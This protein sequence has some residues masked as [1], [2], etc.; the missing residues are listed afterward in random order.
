MA[1]VFHSMCYASTLQKITWL[2]FHGGQCGLYIK[3]RPH[4]PHSPHHLHSIYNL[5]NLNNLNGNDNDNGNGNDK[6][7]SLDRSGH[8][9]VD[10]EY[11]VDSSNNGYSGSSIR[12]PFHDLIGQIAMFRPTFLSSVPA[13]WTEVY[14][15]YTMEKTSL[16][17]VYMGR[18]RGGDRRVDTNNNTNTD[19]DITT[20]YHTACLVLNHKY[21]NIFGDRLVHVSTGSAHTPTHILDFMRDVI[22]VGPDGNM[23]CL[24]FEGYGCMECGTIAHNNTFVGGVDWKIIPVDGYTDRPDRPGV[25]VGELIVKT[26]RMHAEYYNNPTMSRER[27]SHDGYFKTGDVV[28][29]SCMCRNKKLGLGGNSNSDVNSSGHNSIESNSTASAANSNTNPSNTSTSSSN[30]PTTPTKTSFE[31]CTCDRRYMKVKV[32]GRSIAMLKLADGEMYNPEHIEGLLIECTHILQIY[33]HVEIDWLA[34]V[35]IIVT[36]PELLGLG[37]DVAE[38]L[39]REEISQLSSGLLTKHIPAC[40]VLT[41]TPFDVESG[42]LTISMKTCRPK[43]YS[44]YRTALQDAYQSIEAKIMGA[45]MELILAPLFGNDTNSTSTDNTDNTDST[46]ATHT[47]TPTTAPT[48]TAMSIGA[49]G[50]TNIWSYGLNS[51]VALNMASNINTIY[52]IPSKLCVE[53]IY[54]SQTVSDIQESISSY[55][56]CN[57]TGVGSGTDRG[58]GEYRDDVDLSIGSTGLSSGSG[59]NGAMGVLTEKWK[60]LVL[61]DMQWRPNIGAGAGAGLGVSPRPSISIGG[62]VGVTPLESK[63]LEINPVAGLGSG[64]GTD[65]CTDTATGSATGSG[66]NRETVLLTGGVGFLGVVLLCD[67]VRKYQDRYHVIV[68]I[69]KSTVKSHCDNKNKNTVMSGMDRLKAELYRFQG[70]CRGQCQCQWQCEGNWYGNVSG[71][72]SGLGLGLGLDQDQGSTEDSHQTNRQSNCQ[73]NCHC[74]CHCNRQVECDSILNNIEV[75]EGDLSLERMGLNVECYNRLLMDV[76]IILHCAATTSW[77]ASYYQLRD[78]NVIATRNVL[79]FA[80]NLHVDGDEGGTTSGSSGTTSGTRKPRKLIY[81]ST[82]SAS[83]QDTDIPP[84]PGDFQQY[85][86]QFEDYVS[87]T[88][89]NHAGYKLSKMMSEYMVRLCGLGGIDTDTGRDNCNNSNTLSDP[90]PNSLIPPLSYCIIRPGSISAHNSGYSNTTDF[91]TRLIKSVLNS[92]TYPWYSDNSDNTDNTDTSVTNGFSS[93]VSNKLEGDI[94]MAP[95]DYVSAQICQILSQD[96]YIGQTIH[97]ANRHYTKFIDIIRAVVAYDGVDSAGCISGNVT[98]SKAKTNTNTNIYIKM[99]LPDWIEQIRNNPSDPLVTLANQLHTLLTRSHDP[100]P[101]HGTYP[102]D[103]QKEGSASGNGNGNDSAT[104]GIDDIDGIVVP[105][106]CG[107]VD[108]NAMVPVVVSW[109]KGVECVA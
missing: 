105:L 59:S 100:N 40:F 109:L 20:D 103:T 53:L 37:V 25:M 97:I 7:D 98:N 73:C 52:G 31:Y 65:Y 83:L 10:R 4:R 42:L 85:A 58:S 32:I 14:N 80:L 44:T 13:F 79:E 69:R 95:V 15:S 96:V 16:Y 45:K 67:L 84:I 77:T 94:D 21:S 56:S 88:H 71:S 102:N 6:L 51:L 63:M 86:S 1:C 50:N 57:R 29:V 3:H 28:E 107:V 34:P 92:H 81:I 19:T 26:P 93:G 54:Q 106:E 17:E 99:S 68:I 27:Y 90:E 82:L 47:N 43:L 74:N 104:L 89:S 55:R 5:N 8:Y 33:I 24:T 23:K 108:I 87:N 38:G 39:I 78:S 76:D 61:E 12:T 70:Q 48:G 2:L 36:T 30:T 41:S 66:S 35:A 91:T 46:V 9:K 75:L 49:T 64:T 18:G 101:D 62:G 72:V 11:S 22:S 60:E